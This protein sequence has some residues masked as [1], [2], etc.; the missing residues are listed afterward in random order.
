VDISNPA[1]M[2]KIAGREDPSKWNFPNLDK[3]WGS[4]DLF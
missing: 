3:M 4:V 1:Y 2:D